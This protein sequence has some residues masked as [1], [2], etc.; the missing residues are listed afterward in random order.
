[1]NKLTYIDDCQ[2]DQFILRKILSRYGMP[3][4]LNCSDTVEE[5][6]IQLKRQSTDGDS[7]PDII[8]LDIYDPFL[9][10]WEFL[11]RVQ[12]MYPFL[13]KPVEVFILSA[14]RYPTDVE[15]LKQYDFVKAF[16]VKPITKEI[17]VQLIR[18]RE[19]TMDRLVTLEAQ[20]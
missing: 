3:C 14:S 1:M 6:L 16:I 5:V 4:E 12:A 15:R 20:N 2:L 13:A 17:L 18:E 10:A 7:L 19:T 9:N 11:D 8:L